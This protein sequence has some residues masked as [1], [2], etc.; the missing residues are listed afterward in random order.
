MEINFQNKLV[1]ITGA[2][3]GIG[4]HVSKLFAENGAK[5][6]MVARHEEDLND[7]SVSIEGETVTF[8]ADVSQRKDLDAIAKF[9]N[10]E[11]GRLDVLVNNAGTNIRKA[12]KDVEDG[13]FEELIN[14]NLRS[15]YE[16]TRKVYPSLKKSEQGNVIFMSSVAGLAHLRTGAIYAMSKAAMNQL[17]KNLAAEWAKDG[18]RVNAIAPW[19]IATPLAKQVLKDEA[20]K[21]EVLDRTP[22]KR[23]GEPDEVASVV[24]FLCSEGAGYITGQTIAVDG[25]FSIYGF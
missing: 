10:K 5:V 20:Y 19:Y 24:A 23:I 22:M 17:T 4:Y 7:A 3:K 2:S 13:E 18:I 16:L 15:G 12:V 21:K 25:G 6:I 8:S 11:Y 9:V 14:T 1:L